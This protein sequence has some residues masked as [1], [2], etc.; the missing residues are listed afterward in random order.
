M[1][2]SMN[3]HLH[4]II[5]QLLMGHEITFSL[6]AFQVYWSKKNLA[7]MGHFHLETIIYTLE[8]LT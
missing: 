7:M 2:F 4:R 5:T 6:G 3:E 1:T 8:Y